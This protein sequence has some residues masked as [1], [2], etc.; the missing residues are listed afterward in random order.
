MAADHERIDSADGLIAYRD[1]AEAIGFARQE[2]RYG[3][4]V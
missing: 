2:R 4:H 1:R 3:E